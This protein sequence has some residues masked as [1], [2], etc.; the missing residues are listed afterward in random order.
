M[1]EEQIKKRTQTNTPTKNNTDHY[2]ISNISR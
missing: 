1:K 2:N